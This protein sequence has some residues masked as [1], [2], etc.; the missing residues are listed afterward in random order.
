MK[1]LLFKIFCYCFIF[2]SSNNIFAQSNIW[3]THFINDTIK[4]EYSFMTCEFSS[5][6]SQELVVFRFTNLTNNSIKLSYSKKLWNKENTVNTELNHVENRKNIELDP[7]EIKDL[8]IEQIEKRVRWRETIINII[9]EEG[10]TEFI[11]IG[12]GKVL[13]GL[14]K[15]INKDVRTVSINSEIDIKD[16]TI[17]T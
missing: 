15:R 7:N 6:A 14:I 8:L 2:L 1:N 12:P 16:I 3:E 4:I 5:T 13:A 11:E 10:I 9:N 17:K